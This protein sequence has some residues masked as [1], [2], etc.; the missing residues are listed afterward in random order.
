MEYFVYIGTLVAI[1]T[2]LT[3]SLNL[4]VG[5]TGL[6]S[7]AQAAI[8]GVGAYITALLAL[9]HERSYCLFFNCVARRCSGVAHRR[10]AVAAPEE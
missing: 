4:L 6:I 7:V 5:Y 10:V 8:Y 1:Y 2:T 9:P 3:I